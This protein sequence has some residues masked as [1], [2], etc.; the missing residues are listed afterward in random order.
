MSIGN[1]K[2]PAKPKLELLAHEMTC[3]LKMLYWPRMSERVMSGKLAI[4]SSEVEP[5]TQVCG[6]PFRALRF[7][8]AK[9]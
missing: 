4:L 9:R 5:L 7:A 6:T 1:L 8:I 3:V 2:L